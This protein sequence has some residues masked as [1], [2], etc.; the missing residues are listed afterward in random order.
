VCSACLAQL[1]RN[2]RPRFG[3]CNG[4]WIGNVP[5]VLQN[6]S[7]PEQLL[8]ALTFPRCFVFKMHPKI[9]RIQDPSNL[10]RGM[11]GN[12]TSFPLNIREIVDMIQGR[13][14][15]Q[16]VGILPALIAVTFVGVTHFSKNWLKG[17]FRVRRDK[18]AAAL[19]WLLVNNAL[20]Q[21]LSLDQERL[22]LLPEDDIPIEL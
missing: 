11:V 3:I 16:P 9:G 13:K 7:I 8:I 15:P 17:V 22:A 12:V 19:K 21:Q 5:E 10:Q 20:Y 1:K 2:Q 4:L 18:V 6:L 14:L